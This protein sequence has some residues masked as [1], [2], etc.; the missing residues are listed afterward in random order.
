MLHPEPVAN[1]LTSTWPEETELCFA[2]GRTR[3][4]LTIQHRLVHIVIQDSIDILQATLIFDNVF[5]EGPQSLQFAHGTLV[6]VAEKQLP[7]TYPF[8]TSSSKK[9]ITLQRSLLW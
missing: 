3:V 9:M 5:P 6:S 8:T 4:M 7:A 1:V 2:P